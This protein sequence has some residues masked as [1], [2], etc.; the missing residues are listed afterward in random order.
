MKLAVTL[1]ASSEASFD[2]FLFDNSFVRKWVQEFQWCLSNCQINQEES[3]V[4][5]LS[6]EE[7][8]S[9][10]YN[11][12][13][14]INKYLKNFI[15]VR[16][17][18]LIQ[19][20]E[21]FNYLHLKFEQLSGSFEKPTKLFS[22]ANAELKKAI[23][24]LNFYVHR[25]E[26]KIYEIPSLYISFNKDSYRRLRLDAADYEYFQFEAPAG[27]LFLHY[28]E[29]GKEFV[30]IYEDSLPLDYKN[31]KNLHFYS[32]E[33]FLSF[34]EYNA[35]SD[36]N[37]LNFLLENGIDPY[38]KKLGHGKIPLG[39]VENLSYTLDLL[40]TYKHINHIQIKD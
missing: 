10:L 11:A 38:D 3:F 1:G 39:T 36:K 17:D 5:F 25:I 16:D 31:L 21:Y 4:G 26:K 29:L 24:E 30:D 15:E 7:S 12:C 14:T 20:Q 2:I 22:I 37:Y 18:L 6:L 33:A 27:T 23:R 28:A 13:V 19:P 34:T 32:G 35:F 40:K 8:S 9:R